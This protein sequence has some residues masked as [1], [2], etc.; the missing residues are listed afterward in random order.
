MPNP[1]VPYKMVINVGGSISPWQEARIPAMDHGF[2]Y[3]DSVYET[4]RTFRRVPFM[5]ERHLDRLQRSLDRIFIPLPISRKDLTAQIGRTIQAYAD[6]YNTEEDLVVR[7]VLTRGVGPIGLDFALCEQ[8]NFII[9]AFDLPPLTESLFETGIPVV[10]SKIRRNHPRALDPAIKSGNF[11]NNILAFKD[12]KDASAHEAILC[13]A[14]GYLAEGTTSNVFLIKD[15]LV[16]TPHTY[17][18][19]DGI[20]RAIVF[21]EARAAGIPVGETNIPPEALF[22]ADEAF[23][24]SS[25]KAVL[26][27]VRVNGRLVGNGR[28]GPITRKLR[29]LYLGRTVQECVATFPRSIEGILS[30]SDDGGG[31]TSPTPAART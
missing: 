9:Y 7:M 30:Q 12:A 17:G 4:V 31:R 22:N 2:L 13:N 3:G 5:L 11:L 20:T 21:E 19:L 16:W 27:I 23:I 24:T 1:P 28:P 29:E 18:I 25:L 15:G 10:I 26:G 8:S 14:D 6:L